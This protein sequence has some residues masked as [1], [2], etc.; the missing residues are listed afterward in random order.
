MLGHI[1]AGF[2]TGLPIMIIEVGRHGCNVPKASEVESIA[3]AS[4]RT[5]EQV[6]AVFD[7]VVNN[8]VRKGITHFIK[9][10]ESLL[11]HV[12]HY[13]DIRRPLGQPRQVPEERLV[14]LWTWPRPCPASSGPKARA[15]GLRLVATEVD[16]SCGDGPEVS[17]AGEALLLGVAG[18]A[19]ALDELD[20]EGLA[21]LK[22]RVST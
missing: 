20:G 18:R 11:D 17:G 9:P 5:T 12:V 16:W 6:L 21:L 14:A 15:A 7:S 13:E 22:E 8:K 4:V 2:T 10:T 3:F 1:S 19:A